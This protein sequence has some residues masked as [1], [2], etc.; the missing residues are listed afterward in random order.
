M[1]DFDWES[2][3]EKVFRF[4]V[5][6][7]AGIESVLIDERIYYYA[8]QY[9]WDEVVSPLFENPKKMA[10]F[11]TRKL[12]QD[13]GKKNY[14]FWLELVEEPENGLGEYT[15]NSE[16]IEKFNASLKRARSECKFQESMPDNDFINDIIVSL[17]R[18]YIIVTNHIIK[19]AEKFGVEK[20]DIDDHFIC[21]L[22]EYVAGRTESP[23]FGDS[24]VSEAAFIITSYL[25][26]VGEKSDK[27]W[28]N[29]VKLLVGK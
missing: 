14:K 16:I 23:R 4:F 24:L 15:L 29:I 28:K 22:I 9:S 6:P 19:S 5:K 13:D 7:T 26:L 20:D 17:K 11:A 18:E 12:K 2:F 25:I 3:L 21:E 27:T 1:S 10:R 8:Y